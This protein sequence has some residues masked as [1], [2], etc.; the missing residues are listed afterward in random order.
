MR[1]AWRCKA[2]AQSAV[3][4]WDRRPTGAERLMCPECARLV[5]TIGRGVNRVYAPHTAGQSPFARKAR[6]EA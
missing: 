6:G 2:S 4:A 5:K 1:A 3:G